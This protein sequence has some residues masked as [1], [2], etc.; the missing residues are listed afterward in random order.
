MR[1]YSLSYD[2]LDHVFIVRGRHK[3]WRLAHARAMQYKNDRYSALIVDNSSL[4]R[5]HVGDFSAEYLQ[6]ADFRLLNQLRATPL[7]VPLTLTPGETA[8]LCALTFP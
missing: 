2:N 6:S 1:Y 5:D 8:S 3:N 7:G 4:Y